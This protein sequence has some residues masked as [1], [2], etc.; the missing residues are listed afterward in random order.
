MPAT[1]VSP[2]CPVPQTEH[3]NLDLSHEP[4]HQHNYEIITY[5][6]MYTHTQTNRQTETHTHRQTDRQTDRDTHRQTDRQ[7]HTDTH[8]TYVMF[9]L[10]IE[11]QFHHFLL[12]YWISTH[13]LQQMFAYCHPIAHQ[14]IYWIDTTWATPKRRGRRGR[15]GERVEGKM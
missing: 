9:V 4:T 13:Q 6:Y 7:I 2:L 14:L 11:L 15:R 8:T 5:M 10:S 1:W 12:F 3:R